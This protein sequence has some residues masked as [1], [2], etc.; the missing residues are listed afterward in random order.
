MVPLS[1]ERMALR[2]QREKGT[3]LLPE[4]DAGLKVFYTTKSVRCLSRLVRNVFLSTH[5]TQCE[6]VVYYLKKKSD[7]VI[8]NVGF[9]IKK[10]IINEH[11]VAG[12]FNENV[13]D[14]LALFFRQTA[15][16]KKVTLYLCGETCFD[17]SITAQGIT[18]AN[19]YRGCRLTMFGEDVVAESGNTE[20]GVIDTGAN[21]NQQVIYTTFVPMR[22]MC[23]NASE[24]Y[25]EER[26]FGK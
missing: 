9:F 6:A 16:K 19:K 17:E 20:G 21:A 22:S 24:A 1:Y 18:N 2:I 7:S 15:G 4:N 5:G 10:E 8:Q 26:F 25:I 23:I 14:R 13:I 11:S 3:K 12:V